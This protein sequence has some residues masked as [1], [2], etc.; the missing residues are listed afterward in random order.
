MQDQTLFHIIEKAEWSKSQA[1]GR[2]HP[3]SLDKEKFIHL[4]TV[5]QVC[6]FSVFPPDYCYLIIDYRSVEQLIDTTKERKI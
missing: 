6:F 5:A 3:A 4:S 2:Y 1:S